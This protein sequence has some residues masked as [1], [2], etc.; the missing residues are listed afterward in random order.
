MDSDVCPIASSRVDPLPEVSDPV[1]C[2]LEDT[3][4]SAEDPTPRDAVERENELFYQLGRELYLTP[5]VGEGLSREDLLM[6]A[7]LYIRLQK[8]YTYASGKSDM[9]NARRLQAEWHARQEL[10]MG[11]LIQRMKA[12]FGRQP[13]IVLQTVSVTFRIQNKTHFSGPDFFDDA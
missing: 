12:S 8:A 4:S 7:L 9:K 3:Q 2:G 13:G 5:D 6:D 11:K 1:S 10:A